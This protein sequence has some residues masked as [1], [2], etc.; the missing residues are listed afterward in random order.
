VTRVGK[1]REWWISTGGWRLWAENLG[2]VRALAFAAPW[3]S[4]ETLK[5]GP[6]L[7]KVTDGSDRTGCPRSEDREVDAEHNANHEAGVA[8]PMRH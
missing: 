2:R 6:S 1:A 3:S 8:K 4:G 5:W 7:R